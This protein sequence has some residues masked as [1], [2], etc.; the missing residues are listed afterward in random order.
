MLD[1]SALDAPT[2]LPPISEEGLDR[3]GCL[4]P[5]LWRHN[6]SRWL[7]LPLSVR[8]RKSETY[9][10][11]LATKPKEK[12][13][14]N[15]APPFSTQYA[16]DWGRSKGWKLIDRENYDFKNKHHHDL[17]LGLDAMFDDGGFGRVGV[18]GAGR[19]EKAEHYQR[20]LDR[21]GV[22]KA[23][24]RGV[25]VLYLEFERGNKEPLLQEWWA[26]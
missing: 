11:E 22:D 14:A 23:R 15:Y 17:E 8:R 26:A 12:R 13:Q 7:S 19:Y 25:R 2:A 6:P 24:R 18:Q 1:L 9:R 10:A 3:D 20:F 16:I 4:V 5:P 21:G